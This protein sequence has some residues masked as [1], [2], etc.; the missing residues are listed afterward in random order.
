MIFFMK[1]I[2]MQQT[3]DYTIDGSFIRFIKYGTVKNLSFRTIKEYQFHYK[4]LGEFDDCEKYMYGNKGD[5]SSYQ[6]M[7]ALYN[8][9]HGIDK[10][11]AH[12]YSHTFTKKRILNDGGIFRLQKIL[13]HSVLTAVKEYVNMFQMI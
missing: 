5:I 1:R 8:R 6:D 3:K 4:V 7:L 9:K 11:S 13:G 10:T 2:S 12:L